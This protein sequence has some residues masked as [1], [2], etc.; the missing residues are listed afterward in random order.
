MRAAPDKE[1]SADAMPAVATS[2]EVA[3]R[4][5]VIGFSPIDELLG[6]KFYIGT[7]F[8]FYVLMVR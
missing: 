5:S 8:I 7:Y 4:T 1:T 2:A 6:N 3:K